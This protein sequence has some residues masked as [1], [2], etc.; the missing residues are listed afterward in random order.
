[1]KGRI[2]NVPIEPLDERYTEQWSRWFPAEFARLGVPFVN[3]EGEPLTQT[4]DRGVFLDAIST[5][6]YKAVQLQKIT[7]MFHRG[8]VLP[9]DVF[10][11]H[12]FWFPGV[13]MLAYIRDTQG[14]HFKIAGWLHAGTYDPWD[15]L[16]QKGLAYW[17]RELENSWFK[18]ADFLFF[19]S[20]FHKELAYHT[21]VLDL[22]KAWAMGSIVYPEFVKPTLKENICVFPHRLNAEKQPQVFDSVVDKLRPLFPEWQFIKTQEIRRNKQEYTDLLNKS[23][24]AV[25]CAL[26]ETFGLSMVEATLCG[27]IPVVPNRLSYV[28]LYDEAFRYPNEATLFY[29]LLEV[30]PIADKLIASE[31]FQTQQQ[32]FSDTFQTTIKRICNIVFEIPVGREYATY[33]QYANANTCSS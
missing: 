12:D 29:R 14:I 17:G 30:L 25:S 5:N 32:Y 20:F 24:V 7:Q 18:I 1:M 16:A 15:F 10:L 19:N 27:C 11:F 6:H 9:T 23:K 26:Q 21:R 2:I 4:L 3:V 22:D 28:E 33:E 31:R 8:E 13:E